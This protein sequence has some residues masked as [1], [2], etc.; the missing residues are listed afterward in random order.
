MQHDCL[1]QRVL[2][3]GRVQRMCKGCARQDQQSR[4]VSTH[5]RKRK[6]LVSLQIREILGLIFNL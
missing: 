5:K 6:Y 4:Y 1:G 2:H 3:S